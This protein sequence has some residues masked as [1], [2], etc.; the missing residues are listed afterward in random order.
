MGRNSTSDVILS[1]QM[2]ILA[3]IIATMGKNK[4]ERCRYRLWNILSMGDTIDL[5]LNLTTPHGTV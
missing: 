3:L 2:N 5:I 1:D 4:Q